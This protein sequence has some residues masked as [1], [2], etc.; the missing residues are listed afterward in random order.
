MEYPTTARAGEG[1]PSGPKS[2][3][4]SDLPADYRALNAGAG[5]R[6]AGERMV[7]RMTGDDRI[8][9]LNGMCSNDIKRLAPGSLVPALLLTEHA[10]VISDLYVWA[11]NDALMLE[12][13]R[14]MW[15]NARAQLEKFLVADDVEIEELTS[16]TV[17]DIEGPKAHIA[18]AAVA[19]EAAGLEPWHHLTSQQI[20]IAN[21]PRFGR[22]AFTVLVESED[23][24]AGLIDQLDGA[25][26]SIEIRRIGAEAIEVLRLENGIPRIGV[27]TG[28][29]TI[30]LEARLQPAISFD[31]G[32][33]VGQETV[34]R[35]T[36]RGGVRKRLFGLRVHATRIPEANAVVM[37]A[38]N[39]VGRVTSAADSP[40]LG[41]I[42]L[43]I[44]HQSAWAV[45][46]E[47]AIVDA[48]GELTA[49]VSDLPF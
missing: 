33:Y 44:L 10:H 29:K 12:T 27:D 26:A 24:A 41:V 25:A 7:V 34:E 31:K 32:C 13:D 8:A 11:K 49:A 38:G 21:L 30:A 6:V 45:G 22:P 36:S 20:D 16:M 19:V 40:R 39:E 35:A 9:F 37:L 5:C 4:K 42:G 43:S 47:V 46:T 23:A 15:P 17:I 28:A 1:L 14:A 18:V 3:S 48:Q 2:D